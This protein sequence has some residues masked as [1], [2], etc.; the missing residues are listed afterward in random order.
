MA[1]PIV[2][3]VLPGCNAIDAQG[4]SKTFVYRPDGTPLELL[5]TS[6]STQVSSRYWYEVDGL[7]SVVALTD[8][9]G[10]VVDQYQ[11]D[12]W[13][14]PQVTND[15]LHA[16]TGSGTDVENVPQPL[17]YRG[18]PYDRE[19]Q[20][21][22]ENSAGWSWLS[23]RSYDPTLERFLQPDPREREGTRSYVYCDDD[24]LDCSS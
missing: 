12:I 10:N 3:P 20:T 7:G 6:A 13:G 16:G 14:A 23:V 24:P 2:T 17:W 22:G 9:S 5:Y 8:A 11:Y 21:P 18:Y 19:L 15:G 4:C 1:T